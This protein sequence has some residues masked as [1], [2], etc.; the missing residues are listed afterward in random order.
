MSDKVVS[1][2]DVP[3]EEIEQ[4]MRDHPTECQHQDQNVQ[5]CRKLVESP[6]EQKLSDQLL[7]SGNF[8]LVEGRLDEK[9]RQLRIY[10]HPQFKI[11]NYR[12]DFMALVR[13]MQGKNWRF[14][15]E[16]DGKE[17]HSTP[18]Q[19]AHDTRRTEVLT[20]LGYIVLRYPGGALHH[21]AGPCADEIQTFIE[22]V[23]QGTP[24]DRLKLGACFG[25]DEWAEDPEW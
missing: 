16:C 14:A 1:A 2:A 24:P 17:F 13:D 3:W 10:L 8:K 19:I 6:I 11:G 20:Q 21:Q 25:W 12:L 5:D 22:C 4:F 7:K 18:E 9:P 23:T 15:I